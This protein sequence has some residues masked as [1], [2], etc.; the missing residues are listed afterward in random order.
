MSIA[1]DA[2]PT[3]QNST[4]QGCSAGNAGGGIETAGN[5]APLFDNCLFKD[6]FANSTGSAMSCSGGSTTIL[7]CNFEFVVCTPILRPINTY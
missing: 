6:N 3:I 1:G 5:S 2:A 4:I 7:A